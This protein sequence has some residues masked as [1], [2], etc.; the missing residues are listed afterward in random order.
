MPR[1]SILSATERESLLALP[2]A[3]DELIRLYTFNDADLSR[4]RQHRGAANRLGF[5]VQLCYMRYPGIAL[6]ADAEPDAPLLRMVADQLKLPGDIWNDYGQRAETRREHLL[7]LQSA[8]GFQSFTTLS[9]YRAAV[10]S[11]DD[12]A[13]QTDKGIVLARELADGLRRKNVLLPAVCV[14]E[15]ICA[16]SI[17]RAN[18]RIHAALTD[19]LTNVHRQRLDELLKRKEGSKATW[20][21]WLRQSPAKPNSRHMLEHIERLKSWHGLD[22]PAGI[23]RQVHQNLLLKIAREGGQMTP[24]D[25]AK[26]EPQRRYATLVALAIEGMATVTDEIID[27]HDRIIGK[28]FN[29]AK[30]KHQQQ[31]QA[32]GKA[33][34]DKVRLYGRIGQALL[35]AK[36]S[37]G[38]PFAAIEAIMPWD[39]FAASVTEAKTLARPADFDFLHYIGESYATL[40]RYAPQFLDVLKLRAASAAK[41]VL[42]AIDV[43]RGMNSDSARKVPADAPTAFIKPRWAKLV[44]TD[45]GIDRRYYELCALS[46]LKNALR[47]GDVWVQGSRQFKDFDEYLVPVEKFVTL[48]LASELPLAVATDCDQYLRERLELLEEQ[49]ATVNRMAAANDLPDAIITTAS[50][51]KITPL[52][53]AVPDTAQALIDQTAML[54]PHL[55]ITELLMEVDEWTG[56]TR[57]FTH[58]KTGDTAKDKTLLMTTVLADA[59]NLGLTKMAESCP[60]TTY[61]KLS[62]LQ[63]WHV[64]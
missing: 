62:W 25:L 58:M 47:S 45:E 11:L 52:D 61:A 22:L 50:G 26:F 64:R 30:N 38:D 5:A 7:E 12:L 1:R 42:D 56:F 18:R 28:L 44:L 15:R 19:T 41:G 55:K 8:Y 63:A 6:T 53:A 39:T 17:T 57:H 54:L 9:H 43:L 13:W 33:I 51:L 36:Q 21:A 23:E 59:I 37:G 60:G 2:D 34:N 14:M 31:F 10:H 35:D 46:E 16:E 48:K 32:S 4:I 27:L 20:L 49:L 40:R 24:A 29:A 3:K